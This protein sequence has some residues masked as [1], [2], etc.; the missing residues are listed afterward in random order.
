MNWVIRFY[1]FP[2]VTIVRLIIFI[3]A[4][5]LETVSNVAYNIFDPRQNISVCVPLDFSSGVNGILSLAS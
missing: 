3:T 5:C 1:H 2:H 4:G